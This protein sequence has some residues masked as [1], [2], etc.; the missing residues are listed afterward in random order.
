MVLIKLYRLICNINEII[1]VN[2]SNL[3]TRKLSHEFSQKKVELSSKTRITVQ[4]KLIEL[5]YYFFCLHERVLSIPQSLMI[6]GS[7]SKNRIIY[8]KPIIVTLI[9]G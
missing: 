7:K 6:G 3:L 1:Y 9:Q 8:L 4:H 5:K 2:S